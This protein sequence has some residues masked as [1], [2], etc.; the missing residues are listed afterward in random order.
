M[1]YGTC[2]ICDK[3]ET[4]TRKVYV[5]SYLEE[6]ACMSCCDKIITQIKLLKKTPKVV[7]QA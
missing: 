6:K 4:V 1:A 5:G 2:T 3:E 7:I